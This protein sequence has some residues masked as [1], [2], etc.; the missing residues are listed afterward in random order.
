[1]AHIDIEIPHPFQ[2]LFV[3]AGVVAFA[4]WTIGSGAQA[5]GG[6]AIEAA[7]VVSQ[8]ESD[9][10]RLRIEQQ[11][12]ARQEEILRYELSLLE[13]SAV[14]EWDEGRLADIRDAKHELLSL[15]YDRMRG[16]EELK[17]S[18]RQIWDAQ[19]YALSASRNL[20]GERIENLSWPVDPALGISAFFEDKGYEQRFGLPHHAVDIPVEQDSLV[21]AP[22]D[23]IV[24]RVSENGMGFNAVTLQHGGGLATLY[25]HVSE[26]LVEEGQRVREGQP[27]ARSGGQ[28]GTA[29]A[30]LLSTGPHLHF[31]VIVDGHHVDPMRYL[32]PLREAG[33][34]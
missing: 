29:G 19:G 8:A 6:S 22:A 26:F 25:G 20:D 28:P 1:M 5:V 23:G 32:P 4:A 7:S 24:V 17:S 2:T 11:V 16:E 33:N 3:V 34:E 10:H 31:E 14:D 12:I 15:L 27:I 13:A 30:G 18:L 21:Y 9:V